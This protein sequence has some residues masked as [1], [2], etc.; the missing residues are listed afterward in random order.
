M[1]FLSV[2]KVKKIGLKSVGNNVL[3]SDKAVFYRPER[4]IIGNNVRIDDFC[5]IANN[6]ILHNYI[7]IAIFAC[8]LSDENSVIEMENF[9]GVAYQSLLLTN[10]DDYSGNFM[11]NPTITKKFRFIYSASIHVG[12]HGLVGTGTTILPGANIGEGASIGAKSLLTKPAEPWKIYSGIPAK[13]IRD[14]RKRILELE[15][16]FILEVRDNKEENVNVEQRT[17]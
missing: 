1:A 17:D 3:I 15:E 16:K 5:V 10:T 11:T 2:E 4:I 8:L 14:R 6:V 12:C 13:P 9:S 7:H